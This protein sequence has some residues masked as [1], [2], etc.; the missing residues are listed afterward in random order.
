MTTAFDRLRPLGAAAL[1][2]AA[3]P[4]ATLA[5]STPR[6]PIAYPATRTVDV[7]D[8]FG[9]ATVA[10]PYRWLEDLNAP[11]TAQWVTAEN[12]VTESYLS[13]LPLRAPLRARITELWNSPRVSA[14]RW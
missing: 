13:T 10:D 9:S 2:A 8:H 6:T 1:F 3:L 12:A 4:G 14:P 11:E 5:Q 7:V